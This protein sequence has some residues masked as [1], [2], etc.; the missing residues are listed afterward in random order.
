MRTCGRHLFHVNR[1]ICL[2][3]IRFGGMPCGV[4][5][6]VPYRTRLTLKLHAPQCQFFYFGFALHAAACQLGLFTGELRVRRVGDGQKRCHFL[7]V[8]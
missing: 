7:T 4:S 8:A 6:T 3:G 5:A 2:S 1:W